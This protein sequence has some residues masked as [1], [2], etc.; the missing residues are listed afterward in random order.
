[1]LSDSVITVNDSHEVTCFKGFKSVS[2]GRLALAK[3]L[4]KI[5]ASLI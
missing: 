2:N 3:S 5:F 1:M 4:H